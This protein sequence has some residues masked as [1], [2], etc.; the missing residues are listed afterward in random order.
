MVV[1][2]LDVDGAD[3]TGI[4]LVTRKIGGSFMGPDGRWYSNEFEIRLATLLMKLGVPF[5]PHVF[6][7]LGPISDGCRQ[8]M[9]YHPDFIF[10][11]ARW[12]WRPAGGEEVAVHGF[13]AKSRVGRKDQVKI[14]R[15]WDQRRIRVVF[16]RNVDIDRFWLA[17]DLPLRPS[18]NP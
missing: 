2:S 18:P 6:F 9:I 16:V 3:W 8:P 14:D 1:P 5:T 4:E 15:L 13:E 12:L 17:G 11:Q 10:D 7:D